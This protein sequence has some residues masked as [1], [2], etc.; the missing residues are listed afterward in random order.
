MHIIIKRLVE[1]ALKGRKLKSSIDLGC[2][3]GDGGVLIR[4]HTDH[5]VGV[6]LDTSALAEAYRKG[7]YDELYVGDMRTFPLGSADSIFMFD[8]I[9]HISKAEGYQ[10]LDKI[11]NR[12]IMITTPWWSLPHPGHKCLWPIMELNRMG[13]TTSAHSFLPDLLMTLGY[14]GI[15]LAYRSS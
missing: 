7:V 11:G 13:F 8:T 14:G 6:D 1:N 5:L 3:A 10:L 15:I 2:G 12:F 4:S 9:E